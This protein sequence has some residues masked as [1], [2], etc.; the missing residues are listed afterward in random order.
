MI[1]HFLSTRV[2]AFDPKTIKSDLLEFLV[3][4]SEYV[5]IESDEIPHLHPKEAFLNMKE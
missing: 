1:C 4:S 2:S 5:D 3:R